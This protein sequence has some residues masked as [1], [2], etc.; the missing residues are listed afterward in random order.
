MNGIAK[1]AWIYFMLVLSLVA[2]SQ[3][4]DVAESLVSIALV[5]LVFELLMRF[6][7][8]RNHS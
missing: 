7:P 1:R 3:L 8:S 2:I 4:V 5:A 6:S